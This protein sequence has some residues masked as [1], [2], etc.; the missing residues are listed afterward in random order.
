MITIGSG[1]NK[2]CAIVGIFSYS[3][4]NCFNCSVGHKISIANWSAL[5]SLK[6]VHA[7]IPVDAQIS[8]ST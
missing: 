6:S 1:S 2:H 7:K 5:F 3:S 4:C 8:Q